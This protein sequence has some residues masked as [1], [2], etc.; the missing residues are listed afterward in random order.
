[1]KIVLVLILLSTLSIAS[2]RRLPYNAV[3]DYVHPIKPT[4][5]LYSASPGDSRSIGREFGTWTTGDS[6][7]CIGVVQR[8]DVQYYKVQHPSGL[9]WVR[10]DQAL[11]SYEYRIYSTS[12][13]FKVPNSRHATV[14]GRATEG[15]L[16]YGTMRVAVTS[17]NLVM[18]FNPTT[19]TDRAF[20]VNNIPYADSTQYFVR[21]LGYP[22][23]FQPNLLT[24]LKL[25]RLA[26]FMQSGEHQLSDLLDDDIELSR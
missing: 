20:S 3:T 6:L 10:S 21:M 11:R 4:V 12:P 1:M 23:W 5:S 13:V 8:R 17:D 19:S 16:L 9:A 22:K 15:I 26:Y 7:P 2:C 24:I 25:Q 14:W 18:T